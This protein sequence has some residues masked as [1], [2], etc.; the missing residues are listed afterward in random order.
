MK[1]SK[2]A[3]ST[4]KTQQKPWSTAARSCL[5]V[6]TAGQLACVA[7]EAQVRPTPPPP[8]PPADCPAGAVE[9][10][11]ELGIPLDGGRRLSP[12]LEFPGA[13]YGEYVTVRPGAGATL[14]SRTPWGKLPSQTVFSGKLF[15]G[16]TLVYGYFTEAHTPDGSTYS[17]CMRLDTVGDEDT[18][19][20]REPGTGQHSARVKN[21]HLELEAVER[22]KY[23]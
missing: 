9:S 12:P 5:W 22:L 11:K 21:V 6:W 3:P 7:T 1:P 4:P 19:I 14:L 13:E 18:G 16:E 15:I 2:Q 23:E 8:P 10:M 20:P 17:V